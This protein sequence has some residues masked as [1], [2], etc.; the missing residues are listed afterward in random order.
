[1]VKE[2]KIGRN[3]TCPCGSGR[4]YKRCC[5]RKIDW[6]RIKR[7]NLDPI[8]FLSVRGRNIAFFN[9]VLEAL[10]LDSPTPSLSL[11]KYKK[12]FTAHAVRKIHEAV[13]EMWPLDT[14]LP[15]VFSNTQKEV[16]GLY[17]GDY[18]IEN[19]LKGIVRHSVYSSKLIVVDPFIYPH[20]LNREF[21]PLFVPDQYREHTLKCVNFW[22]V[23]L[24]WIDGG[25]VEIIRTPADFDRRLLRQSFETQE[26]KIEQNPDLK[27][28]LDKSVEEQA[29]RVSKRDLLRRMIL[30]APDDYLRR[31][32]EEEP[33]A[34]D[35]SVEDYIAYIHRL[36]AQDPEFL[37]PLAAGKPG[38]LEIYSTGANYEVARITANL[39]GS[40]LL[41][42]IDFK[43]KEIEAARQKSDT[44]NTAWEP[45]AKAFAAVDLKFLNNVDLS[46]ALALRKE[47]R[48][49]GMRTLLRRVWK[50][51]ST[52]ESFNEE[53]AKLLAEELKQEVAL[54]QVEWKKIDR[55]LLKWFGSNAVFAAA[56]LIASGHGSFLT[57]AVALAGA[58]RLGIAQ[59]ERR[60]F[61]VRHPAGFF[62]GVR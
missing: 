34:E 36:R 58:V 57:A 35:V 17:I 26:K 18:G 24:P 9:R 16:T 2:Y 41:T 61:K 55:S 51:A 12:S 25:I 13:V 14:D 8:P 4:K 42:D 15:Q 46:H 27:D 7:E 5:E 45:F 37:E 1:M 52:P 38:Q 59:H 28:A 19:V 3:E 60:D 23:L 10:Q 22:R 40:Y 39:T 43:W 62:L 56:G 21:D 49:E 6:E 30:S 11:D 44:R 54:A 20:G 53:N 33:N 31:Q 32:F 47:G 50:S 48:L 29:A